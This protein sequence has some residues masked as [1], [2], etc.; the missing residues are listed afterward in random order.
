M[1]AYTYT[2]CRSGDDADV[3]ISA[4]LLR[5]NNAA[6]E[7]DILVPVKENTAFYSLMSNEYTDNTPKPTIFACSNLFMFKLLNKILKRTPYQNPNKHFMKYYLSTIV[8][9]IKINCA[10][11]PNNTQ[12]TAKYTTIGFLCIDHKWP[13]SKALINELA[14]YGKSY[15]DAFFNLLFEI[16]RRDWI[17]RDKSTSN[18]QST[19]GAEI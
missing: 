11:L 7:R 13:I 16:Q 15:A 4:A 5:S 19:I 14:E 6:A 3:R 2:L 9:P 17:I 8:V 12:N 1:K 10:F 18:Q